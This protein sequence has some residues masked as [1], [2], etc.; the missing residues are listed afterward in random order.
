MRFAKTSKVISVVLSLCLAASFLPGCSTNNNKGNS[1]VSATPVEYNAQGKFSTT[2]TVPGAKFKSDLTTADV[3]VEY[4]DTQ[5]NVEEIQKLQEAGASVDNLEAKTV[6]ATIESV[7]RKSNDTIEVT[8][9]DSKVKENAP[10]C[11]GIT[12]EKSKTGT[13]NEASANID[14]EY[15][16]D[17]LQPNIDFVLSTDKEIRLTLELKEGTYSDNVA[18][19]DVTLS[20]AFENLTIESISSAGKNLTMQLTGEV[21]KHESSGAYLDGIVQVSKDAITDAAV[22]AKVSIPVQT[23]QA[24]FVAQ[25]L[26]A[27]GSTVTVP[28]TLVGVTDT[29]SLTKDSIKFEKDVHVTDVKKDSDTQVTLTLD[30]TGATDANSAAEILDG[31]TVTLADGQTF[32][33]TLTT[34][35]FYPVFDFVEKQGSDLKFTYELYANSGTF[36]DNFSKSQISLG[37]EFAEGKVVSLDKKS[38]S[39]AELVISV[40]AGDS[41]ADNFEMGGVLTLAAGAMTNTWGEATSAESSYYRNYTK[42]EMGRDFSAADIDTMKDIVGGFGNTTF[43]TISSVVSNAATAYTAVKT[44]LELSGVIKSDHQQEMEKL[45]SISN[46]ITEVQNTLNQHTFMLNDIQSF[47]YMESL[48]DFNTKLNQLETYCN[49]VS[50]Y[51]EYASSDDFQNTLDIKL[52]DVEKAIFDEEYARWYEEEAQR[53]IAER[54]REEWSEGLGNEA[55][56]QANQGDIADPYVESGQAERDR[57]QA[58]ADK[59]GKLYYEYS[60]GLIKAMKDADANGDGRFMGFT[61]NIK[62]L[63]EKFVEVSSYLKN[64]QNNPIDIF[65]KSCTYIYNFDTSSYNIREAYRL[66]LEKTLSDAV[67]QISLYYSPL[68]PTSTE[69]MGL[70]VNSSNELTNRALIKRTDAKA[71]LYV[72]GVDVYVAENPEVTEHIKAAYNRRGRKDFGNIKPTLDSTVETKYYVDNGKAYIYD[73]NNYE[74]IRAMLIVSKLGYHD[75]KSYGTNFTSNEYTM[76]CNRMKKRG[77]TLQEE[78]ESA[79][80]NIPKD[81]KGL[82]VD[83]WTQRGHVKT[84]YIKWNENSVSSDVLELGFYYTS[85]TNIVKILAFE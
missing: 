27:D 3:A 23:E 84:K 56:V 60:R 29:N 39:V 11:Y 31:Q 81:A 25:D 78:F 46:Q 24:Q 54:Q 50:K 57:E 2:L 45:D 80:I 73:I 5:A 20:G 53:A 18:K 64:T 7:T 62:H 38:D 47:Q 32:T 37:E 1:E 52:K 77:V 15:P 12:V 68:N 21:A 51:Y 4:D 26:S 75:F 44:I 49:R 76:F 82:S 30:V 74:T 85:I 66:N 61:D 13:N 42:E 55:D 16:Q 59:N 14:V 72:K 17:I 34:A 40:P 48:R 71:R 10:V 70:Y 41:D 63:D 65:D 19:E 36:A 83:L 35:N 58:I 33:S 67:S 69:A 9:A 28:L 6:E 79:G 43:G 22:D 8:F